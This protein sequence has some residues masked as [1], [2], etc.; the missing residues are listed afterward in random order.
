MICK[1]D[2]RPE[3]VSAVKQTPT[4]AAKILFCQGHK[5]GEAK[6]NTGEVSRLWLNPSGPQHL[7]LTTL[8]TAF[9]S[10]TLRCGINQKKGKKKVKQNKNYNNFDAADKQITKT[11]T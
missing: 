1:W 10:V 9:F 2:G 5:Q 8:L 11:T 4:E 3:S 6:E 7:K